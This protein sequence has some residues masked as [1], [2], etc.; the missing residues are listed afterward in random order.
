[1]S[2]SSSAMLSYDNV[3]LP[4]VAEITLRVLLSSIPLNHICL[5]LSSFV[6][7]PGI[8]GIRCLKT[9]CTGS[10]NSKCKWLSF[11]SFC[12]F[13]LDS[14]YQ[15]VKKDRWSIVKFEVIVG[16]DGGDGVCAICLSLSS[17]S[18]DIF[19]TS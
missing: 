16:G 3:I 14:Y 2:L 15:I 13:A 10:P 6:M 17:W 5:S 19:V 12:H 1:M 7:I 9:S 8:P 4:T 11:L 18:D